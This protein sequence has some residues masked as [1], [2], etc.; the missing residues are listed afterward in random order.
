MRVSADE[1]AG[2]IQNAFWAFTLGFFAHGTGAYLAGDRKLALTLLGIEAAGI[3]LWAGGYIGEELSAGAPDVVAFTRP[4]QA[5]GALA[6]VSSWQLD[7]L[8]T[9]SGRAGT[10]RYEPPPPGP[11]VA[12]AYY[13][14]WSDPRQGHLN[15]FSLGLE[16]PAGR[17][18]RLLDRLVLGGDASWDPFSTSEPLLVG[19]RASLRL[20]GNEGELASR[21]SLDLEWAEERRADQGFGVSTPLASLEARY[22]LAGVLPRL[23]NVVLLGR[24]GYGL[25]ALHYGDSSTGWS[26]DGDRYWVTVGEMGIVIPLARAGR[27]DMRWRLVNDRLLTMGQPGRA[28][29][30]VGF[31]FQISSLMDLLLS[32][33]FG[34]GFD[35]W[36]GFAYRYY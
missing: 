8:G 35:G 16:L 18:A 27:M 2:S 30:H 10:A 5:L 9:F 36:L 34:M 32:L 33:N 28:P 20:L 19:A 25:E 31:H 17:L 11:I 6:F 7:L 23:R 1:A 4:V 26:L 14:L 21:L 3:L 24:W 13:T 29:Y 15:L 22:D 12:T